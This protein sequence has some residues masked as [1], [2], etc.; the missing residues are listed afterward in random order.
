MREPAVNMAASAAVR[1]MVVAVD[2]DWMETAD[3]ACAP[4]AAG[5]APDA[6]ASRFMCCAPVARAMVSLVQLRNSKRTLASRDSRT[7]SR[8][9]AGMPVSTVADLLDALRVKFWIQPR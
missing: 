5:D 6:G 3:A 2:P 9:E 8:G 4:S 1:L 7:C